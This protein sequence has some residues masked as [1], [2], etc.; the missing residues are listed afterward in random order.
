MNDDLSIEDYRA[1]HELRYA[2]RRFLRFSEDAARAA[3][4]EPQQ[5]QLLLAIKGMPPTETPNMAALAERL[6]LRHHSVVE[7]VDRLVARGMVERSRGE[8]DRRQVLVHLT[9]A[10]EQ[11]LHELSVNHR[12]QLRKAAPALV[13]VLVELTGD[14]ETSA[15]ARD[16]LASET[17]V[18]V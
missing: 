13:R 18:G 15:S 5:H 2:I 4:I 7:L 3:G 9:P 14:G 11:V 1:L 10:G 12:A 6:Q 16:E 8:T 17:R